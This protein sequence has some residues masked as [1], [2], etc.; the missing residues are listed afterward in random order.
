MKVDISYREP[1]E[2]GSFVGDMLLTSSSFWSLIF[3]EGRQFLTRLATV[4]NRQPALSHSAYEVGKFSEDRDLNHQ[5][6]Y[7]LFSP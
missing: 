2:Q 1:C 7:E 3:S 5:E 6:L 4:V